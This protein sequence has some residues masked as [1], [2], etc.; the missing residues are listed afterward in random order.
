MKILTALAFLA[1]LFCALAEADN[2]DH[3]PEGHNQNGEEVEVAQA[4]E[5]LDEQDRQ[6]FIRQADANQDGIVCFQ[7]HSDFFYKHIVQDKTTEWD[8]YVKDFYNQL[9]SNND[10]QVTIQ[11]YLDIFEGAPG[12]D[13][14]VIDNE[15][16]NSDL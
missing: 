2:A 14:Q 6:Q 5:E 10:E 7:E 3:I 8:Q 9:D 4:A 11:E 16:V 13:A 15:E 12:E 1:L